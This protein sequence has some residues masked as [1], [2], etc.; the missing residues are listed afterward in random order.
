[1]EVLDQTVWIH[2]NYRTWQGKKTL[3]RDELN[4]YADP[5]KTP[6]EDLI[7][8]GTKAIA[9]PE[10]LKRINS[11]GKR[12]HRECEKVC[13][14]A[15][16]AYGTSIEAGE[17]LLARLQSMKDEHEA[18]IT[19]YLDSYEQSNTEWIAEHPAW[20]QWLRNSMM[21]R[22]EI[23]N[24]FKFEF[25]AYKITSGGQGALMNDGL[26]QEQNGLLGQLLSEI[27]KMAAEAWATSY[28]NKDRAGQK[29]LSPIRTMLNKLKTL[30]YISSKVN[31]LIK[32]VNDVLDA[33]PKTGPIEGADLSSVCGLL[34]LLGSYRRMTD[35]INQVPQHQN[36]VFD[37]I[38]EDD[39]DSLVASEQTDIV[40]EEVVDE[41]TDEQSEVEVTIPSNPKPVAQ[42]AAFCF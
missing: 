21:S 38:E 20:E 14:K 1:M 26:Q 42:P 2:I 11:L 8:P 10:K 12:I 30:S 41:Q 17:S 40:S 39:D 9:D 6:P 13:L 18:L 27:E 23:E 37:P 3:T 34:N 19:E 31:V 28:E 4:R 24:R 22:G 29:A 33:L 15:F 25:Q 35:F 32:R 16:G 7:T 36:D 5:D